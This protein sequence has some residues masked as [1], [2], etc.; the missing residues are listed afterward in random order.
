MK[1]PVGRPA[2]QQ[3]KGVI[4]EQTAY[5]GY[6]VTTSRFTNEAKESAE[7]SNRIVLIDGPALFRWH[8]DGF[9]L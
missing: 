7:K 2:L 5:R 3:F 8:R 9:R 4:E 1:N 6:F